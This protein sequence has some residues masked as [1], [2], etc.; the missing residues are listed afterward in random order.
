MNVEREKKL[1]LTDG[2][3]QHRFLVN[4]N[5]NSLSDYYKSKKWKNFREEVLLEKKKKCELC[6]KTSSIELHHKHYRN[7]GECNDNE[8]ESIV[9]LCKT[10]HNKIHKA[11]KNYD[12]NSFWRNFYEDGKQQIIEICTN[13]FLENE[14]IRT[15]PKE[16][17]NDE[18]HKRKWVTYYVNKSM[19]CYKK[20]KITQHGRLRLIDQSNLLLLCNNTCAC[21][22][23]G[24]DYYVRLHEIY[25]SVSNTNFPSDKHVPVFSRIDVSGN[26]E[27]GNVQVI[28][29]DCFNIKNFVNSNQTPANKKPKTTKKSKDVII[30][31]RKLVR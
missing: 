2:A 17:R 31:R 21:C 3:E 23:S 9:I 14:K 8:K 27:E 28:C 22:N 18:E 24:L 26:Y 12:L 5:F 19:R 29:K 20:G 25:V 1:I 13:F 15:D 6:E 4:S 30:K 11:V 7:L 16:F 10:C